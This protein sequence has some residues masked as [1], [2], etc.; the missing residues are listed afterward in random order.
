Q[1]AGYA[2]D[3]ALPAAEPGA[4]V[5][6]TSRPVAVAVSR[7]RWVER[8]MR[9]STD[10]CDWVARTVESPEGEEHGAKGWLSGSERT[11]PFTQRYGCSPV[12]LV[13]AQCAKDAELVP[14]RVG[15]HDPR[16]VRPLP[17]VDTAGAE[18][19]ESSH[20]FVLIF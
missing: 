7:A 6:P 17:D 4:A 13:G 12:E 15:Q 3:L 2:V 11:S 14:V 18:R 16:D 9:G 8:F 20:L 1:L 5:P 10:A 19:L